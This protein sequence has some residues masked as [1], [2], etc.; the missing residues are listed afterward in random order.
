MLGLIAYRST[1]G[2]IV[3]S[4]STIRNKICHVPDGEFKSAVLPSMRFHAAEYA[5]PCCRVCDSMLPSMRFHAA[6]MRFHAAEYAI[7]CCP[8]AIPCSRVCDSML[9]KICKHFILLFYMYNYCA[10][11]FVYRWTM[12]DV[13]GMWYTE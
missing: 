11:N 3:T 10:I 4:I 8:Y 7:P 12:E 1:S 6:H 9:S 2:H 5:I 13:K